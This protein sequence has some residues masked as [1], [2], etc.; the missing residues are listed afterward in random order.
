MRVCAL[1]GVGGACAD[2]QHMLVLVWG[3]DQ[4][5][6]IITDPPAVFPRPLIR[7]F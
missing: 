6:V 1:K 2:G 4:C 5:R 7:E 3:L